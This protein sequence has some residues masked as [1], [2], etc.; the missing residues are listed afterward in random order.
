MS[1]SS[2]PLA[3]EETVPRNS[4]AIPLEIKQAAMAEYAAG[5]V[6]VAYISKKYGIGRSTLSVWRSQAAPLRT[7]RKCSQCGAAP[8]LKWRILLCRSCRRKRDTALN[9]IYVKTHEE[10]LKAKR[11]PYADLPENQKRKQLDAKASKYH[12]N[13]AILK[14]IYDRMLLRI[15]MRKGMEGYSVVTEHQ[16]SSPEFTFVDPKGHRH[17]ENLLA[18]LPT[19][20]L[21]QAEP[22]EL[23]SIFKSEAG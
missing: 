16:L 7:E 18:P 4:K 14:R 17:R 12:R 5:G 2:I 8:P 6:D 19:W 22:N 11:T 1:K 9:R 21:I 15:G 23:E 20:P 3:K 10:E 13:Q